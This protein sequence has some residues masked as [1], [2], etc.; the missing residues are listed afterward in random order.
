M[1][2]IITFSEIQLDQL[3][4]H[5]VGNKTMD[6]D[7]RVAKKLFELNEDLRTVLLDYFLN[8]FKLDEVYNFNHESNLE[9]NEVYMYCSH[10]FEDPSQFYDQS[11]HILK[12]LYEKSSH[13]KIKSGEL[14][15]AYLKDCIV[16]DELVDAIGIF[17]AENKD[18]Y[19]KIQLDEEG[20][21][22]LE[23]ERGTNISKLDK[24]AL[25]FNTEQENGFRVVTVD[26][27]SSD[28]KYWRDDFLMLTQI[29][30]NA[31]HTK[32]YMAMC[33]QFAKEAFKEEDK[34]EQVDFLNRSLDYFNTKDEFTLEEFKEDVFKTED[35][36]EKFDN[37]KTT[38]QE[39]Q[40]IE[41]VDNQQ[42]FLI[43]PEAVKKMKR[44]FRNVIQ[45]DTKMEIKIH[46][47]E[48]QTEGYLV[49]GYDEE[50]KMSYYQVF[51]NKEK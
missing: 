16:D 21:Y 37:F 43:A 42:G 47:T 1:E 6:E 34:N 50:R 11:I 5:Y 38:Y 39:R 2:T 28:A 29:Q 10:I 19:I 18:T 32:N 8:S 22:V 26:L 13:S 17:K 45:L 36:T 23:S 40:G 27:K 20:N 49:R 9:M 31:F 7:I 46:G 44:S 33:K 3:V 15:V 14:Y 30:D 48:A 35:Q 51:F 4:L 12:H 25:I 41:E 24:G